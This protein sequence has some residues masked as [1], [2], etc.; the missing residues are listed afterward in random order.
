MTN[1]VDPGKLASLSFSAISGSARSTKD[2]DGPALNS[3]LGAP[4]HVEL[5]GARS[6]APP[7]YEEFL[8]MQDQELFGGYMEE[9]LGIDRQQLLRR[10]EE[11][12]RKK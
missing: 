1:N 11:N 5:F 6:Q 10:R 8:K 12:E 3:R 9:T 4:S 7:N 2:N